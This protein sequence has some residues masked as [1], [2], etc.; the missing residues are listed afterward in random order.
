VQSGQCLPT[1]FLCR[2]KVI[3]QKIPK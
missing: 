2:V 3:T 1:T